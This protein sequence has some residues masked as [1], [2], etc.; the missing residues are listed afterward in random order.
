MYVNIYTNFVESVNIKL[1]K[2]N[3]TKTKLKTNNK[4]KGYMH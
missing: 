2:N 1:L 4:I 3:K